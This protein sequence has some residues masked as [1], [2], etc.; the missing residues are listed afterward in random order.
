VLGRLFQLLRAHRP[1]ILHALLFHA[2]LA[3]RLVGPLAGI[4]IAK[5]LCEIQTVERERLW[6]LAIDNL[7]CRLCR[8]EVGNSPSVVEHLHRRAG[9]PRS[10]LR[11]MWGGVDVKRFAS[12]RPTPRESIGARD[13]EP[14][15][16]WAGRLDPVKGFEE[17]IG[18]VARV[19][20]DRPVRFVLAGQGPYLPRLEALIRTSSVRDRVVLLGCR[21]DVAGLLAAADVFLFGSRTEG[22]PNAVLEAMAAGRAIVATD[23]GGNRDLIRH[24]QTGLL[25]RAGSAASLAEG[26]T[27]MLDRPAWAAAMGQRAQQWA[28]R[29]ADVRA[30]L[31]RWCRFYSSL[32]C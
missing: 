19:C 21:D 17:M 23:I 8:F 3:A 5:I 22:L 6:H 16:L 20:R 27:R 32:S 2:N 4:P 12:A 24:E 31:G 29:H 10:R 28:L 1:D 18:A 26:L 14:M 11:C 15:V 7:T 9:I 25:V 30:V 13:D